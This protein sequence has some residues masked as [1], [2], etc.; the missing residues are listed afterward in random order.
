VPTLKLVPTRPEAAWTRASP[1]R[2]TTAVSRP[3]ADRTG[4]SG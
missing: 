3:R 4:A 1:Y 2:Q